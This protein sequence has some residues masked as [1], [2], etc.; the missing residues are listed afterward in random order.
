MAGCALILSLAN[1]AVLIN[2]SEVVE[3]KTTTHFDSEYETYLEQKDVSERMDMVINDLYKIERTVWSDDMKMQ[4]DLR[5]RWVLKPKTE[6]LEDE[7]E[8]IYERF[9]LLEKYLKIQL[10]TEPASSAREVYIKK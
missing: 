9:N 1:I 4:F 3:Q 2:L 6:M 8:K 10:I 5:G 7:V